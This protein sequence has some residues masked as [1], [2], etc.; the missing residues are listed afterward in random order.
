MHLKPL[1]PN[2]KIQNL[3]TGIHTFSYGT[4]LGEFVKDHDNF[5][6]RALNSHH[7]LSSFM[8]WYCKEKFDAG[9]S[10]KKFS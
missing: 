10:W 6:F 1:S 8:Y 4:K 9:H 5:N 2:V 7:L 3:L